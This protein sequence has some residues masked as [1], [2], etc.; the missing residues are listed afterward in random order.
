MLELR[1]FNISLL[2][3]PSGSK[4]VNQPFQQRV[5][6]NNRNLSGLDL[7][8]ADLSYSDLL[9]SDLSGTNLSRSFLIQAV[10][11]NSTLIRANLSGAF[12]PL[13]ALDGSDLSGADLRGATRWQL[14]VGAKRPD[15]AAAPY[16]SALRIIHAGWMPRGWRQLWAAKVSA[17][18]KSVWSK[19]ITLSG[20][21]TC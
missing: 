21:S 3:L 19:L 8:G 4:F 2:R 6:L 14:V 20:P 17:H 9:G 18:A 15:R 1:R 5:D 13:A 16:G 12:M 7:F 11:S 10:I